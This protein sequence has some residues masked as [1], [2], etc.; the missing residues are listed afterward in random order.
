MDPIKSYYL[1]KKKTK[2]LLIWI[3]MED[4]NKYVYA[5]DKEEFCPCCGEFKSNRLDTGVDFDSV[6]EILELFKYKE[7]IR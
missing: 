7:E 4:S 5:V 1:N 6:E 2:L 3:D